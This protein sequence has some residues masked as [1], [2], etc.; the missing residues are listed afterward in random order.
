[1][2]CYPL[3]I[4]NTK[5]S[6]KWRLSPLL[7]PIVVLLALPLGQVNP[8]QGRYAKLLPGILLYLL[9]LA[10]LMNARGAIEDGRLSASVGVWP[11]HGIFACI[12]MAFYSYTPLRLWMARQ[13][14][15]K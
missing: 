3:I 13:G 10:L 15:Q 4:L 11:V 1:M 8:R 2:Y 5:Q 12:A 14:A 6:Y 9:Y 7:V